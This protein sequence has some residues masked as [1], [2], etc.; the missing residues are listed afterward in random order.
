[1]TKV[2]H[3]QWNHD[4]TMIALILNMV[5]KINDNI[6]RAVKFEGEG[7]PKVKPSTLFVIHNYKST[8]YDKIDQLKKLYVEDCFNAEYFKETISPPGKKSGEIDLYLTTGIPGEDMNNVRILHLFLSRESST[9]AIEKNE[10]YLYEL[11]KR[12]GSLYR[13][14]SEGYLTSLIQCVKRQLQHYYRNVGPIRIKV[15]DNKMFL[16]HEG[17]LN[18]ISAVPVMG[19]GGLTRS[20]VTF[21]PNLD[22]I[23]DTERLE[24]SIDTPDIEFIVPEDYIVNDVADLY[25]TALD[26]LHLHDNEWNE[27]NRSK[28]TILTHKNSLYIYGIRVLTRT[29]IPFNKGNE[30]NTIFAEPLA[31]LRSYACEKKSGERE[32]SF[33]KDSTSKIITNK[34]PFG[35]FATSFYIDK[36]NV[37][38]WE[39][40]DC[41]KVHSAN[42]V[43]TIVVPSR[44]VVRNSLKK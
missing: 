11:K 43:T 21:N 4:H 24:I 2:S 33:E 34:R 26:I 35:F 5:R 31:D 12:I 39:K 15:R 22:I 18:S 44:L 14:D 32:F 28:M 37:F 42:G 41:V 16:F 23:M 8:D 3:Y 17:E 19:S 13:S 27:T 9:E 30:N 6:D 29:I 38:T 20:V 1:M 10:L 25:P 7:K 40:V 36:M